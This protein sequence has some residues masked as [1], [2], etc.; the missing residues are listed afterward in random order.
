ME[1]PC[2]R[3]KPHSVCLGKHLE[4][5]A[6]CPYCRTLLDCK[7]ML[8]KVIQ[9][10]QSMTSPPPN[11][12]NGASDEVTTTK[13]EQSGGIVKSP[14]STNQEAAMNPPTQK[15]YDSS[16]KSG[17]IAKTTRKEAMENKRKHQQQQIERMK[18][19]RKD[20][21]SSRGVSP[22][23]VVTVRVD[24]GVISYSHG[25]IGVVAK[26][27]ESGGILVVCGAGL[28]CAT[29]QMK[30]YWIPFDGYSVR[31][32]ADEECPLPN[33]MNEVRRIISIEI[34][35]KD[36]KICAYRY[37]KPQEASPVVY[38]VAPIDH[39]D[40]TA[41]ASEVQAAVASK[42]AEGATAAASIA[43]AAGGCVKAGGGRN[44]GGDSIASA[45]S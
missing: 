19:M 9:A 1:L 42:Q 11:K 44:G 33:A 18:R 17:C 22:G 31:A 28:I 5:Y 10:I 14:K 30:D 34:E 39:L 2:C 45:A 24:N 20:D 41:I 12:Y 26:A 43:S 13:T 7:D 29:D 6:S 36:V 27:K 3:K 8:P 16:D 25:V 4:N 40:V 38:P 35:V 21:I 15:D 32:T 37:L 23:A